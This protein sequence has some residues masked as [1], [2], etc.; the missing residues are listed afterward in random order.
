MGQAWIAW[1]PW[2]RKVW[3]NTALNF[4]SLPQRCLSIQSSPATGQALGPNLRL[5][6]GVGAP[7]WLL[8]PLSC[9]QGTTAAAE[10][11]EPWSP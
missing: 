5:L 11:P 2:G 4:C 9:L 10:T 3:G 1:K 7:M 6:W 8:T